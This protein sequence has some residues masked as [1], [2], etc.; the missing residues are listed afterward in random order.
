MRKS[1]TIR[2]IAEYQTCAR[3]AVQ[4]FIPQRGLVWLWPGLGPP[5]W[6]DRIVCVSCVVSS[7]GLLEEQRAVMFVHKTIPQLLNTPAAA[8]TVYGAR[9]AADWLTHMA[10][11][12]NTSRQ[13]IKRAREAR[14][15][16]AIVMS[17]RWHNC[18]RSKVMSYPL[19]KWMAN[20]KHCCILYILLCTANGET[21]IQR[22]KR[23]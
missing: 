23:V 11:E 6:R 10:H 2:R 22:N 13:V 18:R 4:P 7:W 19:T 14:R 15:S 5:N 17:K 20:W 21:P 9:T 1:F 8:R 16:D 3:H 12:C